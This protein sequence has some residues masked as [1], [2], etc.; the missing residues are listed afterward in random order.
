MQKI[1][2]GK[3]DYIDKILFRLLFSIFPLRGKGFGCQ[4]RIGI[5]SISCC[6]VPIIQPNS[7]TPVASQVCNF[8]EEPAMMQAG[9]LNVVQLP[10]PNRIN[11]FQPIFFYAQR[12]TFIQF[13]SLQ[14]H[15]QIFVFP[16]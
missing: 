15:C 16:S 1:R 8:W 7:E 13:D 11:T 2:F 6:H 9:S 12:A 4:F 10:A 5:R 14:I 3:P